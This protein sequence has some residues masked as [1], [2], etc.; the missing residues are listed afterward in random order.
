MITA[1][2]S[3]RTGGGITG[4]GPGK[5]GVPRGWPTAQADAGSGGAAGPAGAW[6]ANRRAWSLAAGERRQHL[7]HRRLRQADLLVRPDPGGLAVDEE[8]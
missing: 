5:P 7:D 3:L 6:A 1:I 2:G 4:A 8:R